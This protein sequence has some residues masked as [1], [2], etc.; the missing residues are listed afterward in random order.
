MKAKLV[1][2]ECKGNLLTQ[3]IK[4]VLVGEFKIEK[5]VVGE[6]YYISGF[7]R[8]E[9]C[10]SINN[11]VWRFQSCVLGEDKQLVKPILTKDTEELYEQI[12]KGELVEGTWYE[13]EAV[14][15]EEVFNDGSKVDL[16]LKLSRPLRVVEE[17]IEPDTVTKPPTFKI[18]DV[19]VL[20]WDDNMRGNQ[21]SHM[22]TFTPEGPEMTP[23]EYWH[24]ARVEEVPETN[25]VTEEEIENQSKIM[26]PNSGNFTHYSAGVYKR[27]VNQAF[28]NGAKWAIERMKTK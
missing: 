4:P 7:N 21:F 10:T 25:E 26:I 2:I 5:P 8:I 13:F 15:V 6:L 9:K 17:T 12:A 24:Q 27:D 22:H 3:P 23:I 16:G 20:S 11:D 18:D 19:D 1:F 28:I 14:T